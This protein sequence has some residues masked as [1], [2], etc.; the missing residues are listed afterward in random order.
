MGNFSLRKLFFYQEALWG[1]NSVS[2]RK[3]QIGPFHKPYGIPTLAWKSLSP[4]MCGNGVMVRS[5]E[6]REDHHATLGSLL[7]SGNQ[8]TQA[9]VCAI[10]IW[11]KPSWASELQRVIWSL[12]SPPVS[13]SGKI[14]ATGLHRLPLGRGPLGEAQES[15][16]NPSTCVGTPWLNG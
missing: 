7:P 9:Q 3:D 4:P 14:R 8:E 16:W 2:N 1:L 6:V 5:W 11:L 15:V 12:L 13:P 10:N